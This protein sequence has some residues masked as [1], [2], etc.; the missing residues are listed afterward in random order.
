M[1][2]WLHFD[3]RSTRF[4]HLLHVRS[5]EQ[6]DI[7]RL[8]SPVDDLTCTAGPCEIEIE[9]VRFTAEGCT[10]IIAPEGRENCVLLESMTSGATHSLLRKELT[11]VSLSNGTLSGRLSEFHSQ[12][13][14]IQMSGLLPQILTRRSVKKLREMCAIILR[15]VAKNPDSSFFLATHAKE[16]EM[17]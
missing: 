11:G 12:S 3:V 6:C 9:W 7:L 4:M 1:L 5:A 17:G 8:V 16:M 10:S 13:I 14:G 15:L 2:Q